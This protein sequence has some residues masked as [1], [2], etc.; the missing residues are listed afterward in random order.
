M[1]ASHSEQIENSAAFAASGHPEVTATACRIMRTGGNAFDAVIA[2]GV[3]S[4][5]LEPALTSLGGGGFLLARTAAGVATLFD[6]FVD[7]PGRGLSESAF[8]PHFIPVTVRF[9]GSD[10]IFNVGMGAV[11]TP[12]NLAGFLHVHRKLGRLPLEAVLEPAIQLAH[13]G[14]E[15]NTQQAYF[16]RLLEPIMMLT[17]TTQALYAPAGQ[18]LQAGEKLLNPQ[19]AEFLR[20]LCDSCISGEQSFY[21]GELAQ[22]IEQDMHAGQGLLTR[23]DLAAYRVIEREPLHVNYRGHTLLTNPAPSFGGR[24]LALSLQLLEAA[25]IQDCE[26]GSVRQLAALAAAQEY[27]ARYRDAYLNNAL[28]SSTL[29]DSTAQVRLFSRGTTHISVCDGDGNAA[30]MTTSNGE[31][32][33]YLA[34]GTGIML[35]NMLGED[36]LHPDGFHSSPPGLRVASMMA[37]SMLLRDGAVELVLG[38]GGSKRIRTALLQVISNSVDFGM[39]LQQAIEAPRLHWDSEQVQ[40]EPGFPADSLTAIKQHW[41]LNTWPERNMYFGG[42]HAVSPSTGRAAGDPRRGGFAACADE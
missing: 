28:D 41:P 8:E 2:A 23:Q 24:M 27:T 40:L 14:A 19:L 17:P 7:T 30:S 13:N 33:G 26:F 9:P 20:N 36:D 31:G 12:G 18:L 29:A 1:A 22:A 21:Q 10:Q 4:A 42:V 5:V 11:A 3:A 25:E 15:L 32:A 39:P 16:L 34:P 37:P 35:N 6:F 38:S